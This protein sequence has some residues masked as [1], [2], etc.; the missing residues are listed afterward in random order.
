[1]MND[2]SGNG[3]FYFEIWADK[4]T[5]NELKIGIVTKRDFKMDTSFS[6]FE[7]GYAFY[8]LG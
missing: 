4:R 5:D 3:L 1:M 2:G 8:G 6:D 7:Y